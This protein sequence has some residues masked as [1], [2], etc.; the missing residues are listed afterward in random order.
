[1]LI[2][3]SGEG[4]W[5]VKAAVCSDLHVVCGSVQEYIPIEQLGHPEN[6]R[7]ILSDSDLPT[8]DFQ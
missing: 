8:A 7:T 5:E 4:R 3:R 1:M 6:L 2:N